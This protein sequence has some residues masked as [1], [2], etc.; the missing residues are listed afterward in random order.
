MRSGV[1]AAHILERM[2][3]GVLA[4]HIARSIGVSKQAVSQRLLRCAKRA[5]REAMERGAAVRLLAILRR[6]RDHGDVPRKALLRE[7]LYCERWSPALLIRHSDLIRDAKLRTNP[8]L[9]HLR[10]PVTGRPA[11]RQSEEIEREIE[12][13]EWLR[14]RHPKT[15]TN[16]PAR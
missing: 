9:R 11:P 7:L 15:G 4:A 13:M 5:Y 2:A 14:G 3:S 1:D 16:H 8:R 6:I 10:K 12:A